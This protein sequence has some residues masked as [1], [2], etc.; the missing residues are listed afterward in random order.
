MDSLPLIMF[1]SSADFFSKSIFPKKDFKNIIRVANSL[2]QDHAQRLVGPYMYPNCLPDLPNV[3]SSL[4]SVQTVCQICPTFGRALH[5]PKL[6][7]RSAQR[8]IK[9]DQ[10]PNCLPDLPNVW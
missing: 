2:N 1:L 10:C 5:V 3:L 9:P 8:F 4:I 6:F 7:A